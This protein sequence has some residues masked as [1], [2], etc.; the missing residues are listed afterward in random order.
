[1]FCVLGVFVLVLLMLGV[2]LFFCVF[3]KVGYGSALKKPARMV[4]DL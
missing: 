1:M 4:T 3:L 2:F